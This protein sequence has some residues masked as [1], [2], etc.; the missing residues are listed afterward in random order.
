MAR[1]LEQFPTLATQRYP[2]AEWL[3]GEVWQ[4]FKGEDYTSKSSTV[5]SNARTQAKRLGGAVRTR[6]LVEEGRE[7]LVIQYRS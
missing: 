5:L 6:T 2:W 7:S 4:L 1:T 3:N